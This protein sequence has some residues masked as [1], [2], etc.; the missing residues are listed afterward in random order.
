M[1][2]ETPEDVDSDDSDVFK[3]V[4]VNENGLSMQL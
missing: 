4:V 1:A 2:A 3:F